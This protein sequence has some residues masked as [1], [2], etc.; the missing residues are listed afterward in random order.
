M[1]PR[2]EGVESPE[3]GTRNSCSIQTRCGLNTFKLITM[4]RFVMT[5]IQPV[6]TMLHLLKSSSNFPFV[7]SPT[8]VNGRL[9][10]EVLCHVHQL[11][12]VGQDESCRHGGLKQG[13][14]LDHG[15]GALVRL[16]EL[17][18]NFQNLL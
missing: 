15:R 12:P 16:L 9:Q 2:I 14:P 7:F 11:L 8:G 5:C 4:P 3:W 1:E 17:E 10:S 13:Q 6:F 18:R